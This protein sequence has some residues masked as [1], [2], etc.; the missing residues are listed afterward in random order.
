MKI[1]KKS[2][3]INKILEKY[4][5]VGFVPTMGTLHE[6]HISLIRKSK[7]ESSRTVVSIFVNPKQFTKKKKILRVIQKK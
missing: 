3:T 2:N 7:K 6:G 5:N 4:H 1:I